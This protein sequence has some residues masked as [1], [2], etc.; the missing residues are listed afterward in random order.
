[1]TPN[2]GSNNLT[3]LVGDGRG[4]FAPAAGSPISVAARPYFVAL[5]DV[6]G[7][8]KLDLA[9]AHDDITLIT[10]L[11]GDGR[12]GFRPAPGSPVDAGARGG[13]VVL[14]D[15]NGDARRDLVTGTAADTVVVLLGDG[16]GG[17]APASG[18][19]YATGRGPW[20]VAVADVDGDGKP[21]ILTANFDD[22][23]V[24]ILLG[25]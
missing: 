4:G 25:N 13:E 6:D 1:V 15:L 17:F 3:V 19:P 2:V 11:L 22:N 21:D 12:G 5:G 8:H 18:S 16:R 7:D 20:A 10:V 23:N 9:A 14:A 24:R